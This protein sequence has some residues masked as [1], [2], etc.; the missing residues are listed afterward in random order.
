M[1]ARR[2]AGRYN[3]QTLSLKNVTVLLILVLSISAYHAVKGERSAPAPDGYANFAYSIA[4]WGVYGF[5]ASS[6][7]QPEPSVGRPPLYP[8][9]LAAMILVSPTYASLVKDFVDGRDLDDPNAGIVPYVQ[10]IIMAI[11]GFVVFA[12]ARL[13]GSN[14][15]FAHI[16]SAVALVPLLDIAFRY[17]LS[18]N[19]AIPLFALSSFFLA[20]WFKDR[21]KNAY[22]FLAG[23]FLGLVALT[24]V[25]H[26]YY[27]PFVL[28]A[29]V[30][31]PA[32]SGTPTARRLVAG[33]LV[34]VLGF[35]I[36]VGPWV[37]RN[38]LLHG[39][40]EIGGSGTGGVLAFRSEYNTMS[41][42]EALAASIYW[43]PG[44][45]DTLVKSVFP[46]S[47]WE[48][49]EFGNPAGFRAGGWTTLQRFETDYPEPSRLKE[50]LY[51]RVFSNPAG[52]LVATFP[53]SV[54]GLRHV[55][56]FFP[57]ALYA[58]WHARRDQRLLPLIG[59]SVLTVATF[60]VHA[61]ITHFRGRYGLPMIV[62]FAPLAALGL[63][64]MSGWLGGKA[65]HSNTL[66][67]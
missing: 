14:L 33:C 60:V 7:R 17:R 58:L 35:S 27:V 55:W 49:L 3:S 45:G 51:E 4:T 63:T 18:E 12:T 47:A 43:L 53:L 39:R 50:A 29:V 62:G 32:A 8:Y 1:A 46:Q 59:A 41:V 67:Q 38:M 52:H 42:S 24:R 40:A 23:L 28:L 56:V 2:S 9:F 65:R 31:V 16:C 36:A 10:I 61:A 37:G 21:P 6:T 66:P 57:F 54:R 30:F 44:F 48:R 13:F 20:L 5:P 11:V 34:F 15:L 64:T 22:L 26:L 19:L 25:V